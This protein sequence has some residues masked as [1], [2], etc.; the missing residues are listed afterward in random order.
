[1]VFPTQM[2][3]IPTFTYGGDLVC[4]ASVY[5]KIS[6]LSIRFADTQRAMLAATAKS[7]AQV[8]DT[9]SVLCGKAADAYLMFSAEL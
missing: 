1:M 7:G 2:R 6:D 4:N 5:D 9:S 3:V 8:P